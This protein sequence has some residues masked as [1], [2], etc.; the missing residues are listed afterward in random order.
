M[1]GVWWHTDRFACA[2]WLDGCI[3]CNTSLSCTASFRT[4]DKWEM[5]GLLT[6]LDPPRPDTKETIHKAMAFGV[7]VKMITGDHNLIAKE[8]S[9]QLGMGTNIQNSQASPK[10]GLEAAMDGCRCCGSQ[11]R[12]STIWVFRRQRLGTVEVQYSR[13]PVP[14][15]SSAPAVR[16]QA[17]K[18]LCRARPLFTHLPPLPSCRACPR[19]ARTAS[20]PR[21]WARTTARSSWRPTALHRREMGMDIC[22]WVG[23]V[24]WSEGRGG[25][26]ALI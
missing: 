1:A 10:L 6:F 21:T 19:W 5:V 11:R 13:A 7:D 14:A 22:I 8:T 15:R 26:H 12:L 17:G 4:A 3:A 2:W 16:R 25:A 23:G 18:R 9:R 20:R 24:V